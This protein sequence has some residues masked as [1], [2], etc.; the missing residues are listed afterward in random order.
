MSEEKKKPK[1]T[2]QQKINN[3]LR[4]DESKTYPLDGH[5]KAVLHALA[6]YFYYGTECWPSVPLICNYC[7]F[8]DSAVKRSLKKLA[9]LGLIE[10]EYKRGSGNHYKWKI[11]D[12]PDKEIYG[13]KGVDNL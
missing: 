4:S 7:G 2:A 3:F 8:S 6:S 11:P 10:K 1:Q 5:D 9:A 13:K 12:I